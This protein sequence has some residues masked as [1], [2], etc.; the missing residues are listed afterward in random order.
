MKYRLSI[1]LLWLIFLFYPQF[2]LA[3]DYKIEYQVEYLP[4]KT[5]KNFL[6]E[7]NLWMKVTHL[8]SDIYVKSFSLKFPDSFKITNLTA[9][10][11]YEN[12]K[13][14][15]VKEKNF[16]N[17]IIDLNNPN[18]GKD[19]V[20][21]I[22]LK[23]YQDKIFNEV[24]N[25]WESLIPI[26]SDENQTD[27]KVIINLPKEIDK[28]ISIA[29]PKPSL[30]EKAAD[31]TKIYWFK[32]RE[33]ILYV[34][35]GNKQY[36]NF[37]IHY[38]LA[39]DR[40]IPVKQTITLLPDT[41]YQIVYHNR[42]DPSPANVYI[43]EDGNYLAEYLISPKEVKQITYQGEVVLNTQLNQE[44]I[45][46]DKRI[47][48]KQ[49]NYLLNAM[50]YWQLTDMPKI[51]GNS[52]E[53]VYR[54]VVENLNYN[55]D[56]LNKRTARMGAEQVLKNPNQAIC[57]EFSDLYIALS[58]EKG[59][60]TRQIIG[61][62]FSQEEKLRPLSLFG[63]VLHSW[64]EYY[65]INNQYWKQIDPTW[66]N[67]S[68]ID[69]FNSLDLN[70][71]AF[72]IRGKDSLLPLPAGSFKLNREQQ[73]IF[74]T[75]TKNSP[76]EIVKV[77]LVKENLPD[78]LFIGQNY[79]GEFMVK[80]LSNKILYN[81]SVKFAGNAISF[82]NQSIP[83]DVLPPLGEASITVNL[84]PK[85]SPIMTKSLISITAD[86]IILLKKEIRIYPITREMFYFIMF[87]ITI[88]IGLFFIQVI[89]KI[90]KGN[91]R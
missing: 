30:I 20:N 84:L 8:R 68:G 26:I 85:K 23:F 55:Y 87:F 1:L 69:Y 52:P 40:F 44:K 73:G 7:V 59:I 48:P 66:E 79:K 75:P 18:V 11:D 91:D 41:S 82:S 60:F 10:D 28:Q 61:Y 5:E 81:L 29:K 45:A 47:F 21:N 25:I 70:H 90:I 77:E 6:T 76:K 34:V 27:Y 58:R 42:L 36:Y 54:Y 89:K 31:G 57:L 72:V 16:N 2:T 64:V 13:I 22:Y 80:N 15:I 43:D 14:N 24:G 19:S 49:K 17:L 46:H 74:I 51:D 62:S 63:D 78:Q 39:N 50:N 33:K 86:D 83:I 32:P 53:A 35:F 65:D 37:K 38:T 9:K 88:T 3:K 71:I 12:L 56:L 4:R 67:T